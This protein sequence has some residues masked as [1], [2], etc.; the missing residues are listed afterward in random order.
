MVKIESHI[1]ALKVYCGTLEIGVLPNIGTEHEGVMLSHVIA[2]EN[3]ESLI[4]WAKWNNAKNGANA[5]IRPVPG[6]SHPWLLLDDLTV[7]IAT[8]I[9]QK[10]AAVVVET[11]RG[12]CQVRLL[13]TINLTQAERASVQ[14]QLAP[15]VNA[16]PGSTAGDKWGRLA[17]F[18]NRKPGKEGWWT[19]LIAD[20]TQV[21][22]RFDPE[23]WLSPPGGACDSAVF[24]EHRNPVHRGG[25]ASDSEQE[26]GWAVGR[27]AW[28]RNHRP[29]AFDAEVA[30]MT[31][32]ILKRATARHKRNP[33]DYAARTIQAV[34]RN[35]QG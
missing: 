27:L 1:T 17:G 34:L 22:P 32:D 16:D 7:P 5:F 6:D 9:S 12:N 15:K 14:R 29:D 30:R 20:T 21:K 28:F 2:D 8:G 18:Q 33:E 10:Y 31:S 35:I 25:G 13:A 3:R 26:F 24:P 4:K 11:S 19:R 23:R